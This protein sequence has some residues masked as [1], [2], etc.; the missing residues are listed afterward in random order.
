MYLVYNGMWGA[1]RYFRPAEAFPGFRFNT[2][3]ILQV[4]NKQ[5]YDSLPYLAWIAQSPST[6][7]S[8]G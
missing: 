4:L 2:V 8:R 6:N 5:W 3:F 7:L 1:G